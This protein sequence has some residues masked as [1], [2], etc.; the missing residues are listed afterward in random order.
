MCGRVHSGPIAV[1]IGHGREGC[2]VEIF[3]CR[4]CGHRMDAPARVLFWKVRKHV[5]MMQVAAMREDVK[6]L[7]SIDDGE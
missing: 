4:A 5:L 6:Q 1:S 7:R 3:T 2:E